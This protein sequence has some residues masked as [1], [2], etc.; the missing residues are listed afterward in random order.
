MNG[1]LPLGRPTDYPARYDPSLLRAID[2]AS[3]RKNIGVGEPVPFQGEDV[4]NC[5]EL[6]WLRPGG[7]PRVGVLRLRVPCQSPA[8]VESKSLK[9]YLGSFALTVFE[10][11]DEV[12]RTIQSDLSRTTGAAVSATILDADAGGA[13]VADFTGFCLDGLSAPIARYQHAPE[14]LATT[15]ERGADAVHTHLFRTVCPITGQPDWGSMAVAWRGGLVRRDA[16]LA[17]LVSYRQT[18]GFHED[19]VERIFVEVREAAAA[20][21]I[22]VHGR[23]L[24]RGGIDINPF[25]STV[26]GSG[27]SVRLPRQ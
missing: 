21:E 27:P 20:E 11:R 23:F 26:Q 13:F 12:A 19:V 9:L 4:W 14:L 18:A 10:R 24:R 17:Y 22:T 15:G 8:M 16:M 7:L 5:Y 25:R 6:S 1:D 2:R 3:A